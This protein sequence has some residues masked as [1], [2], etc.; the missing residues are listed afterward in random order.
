MS[1]Y[2][3]MKVSPKQLLF[4]LVQDFKDSCYRKCMMII[5]NKNTIHILHMKTHEPY[6]ES[7]CFA[8][9]CY[10]CVWPLIRQL[11]SE[12]QI[13]HLQRELS[14]K[15]AR[16][17]LRLY[18]I[19]SMYLESIIIPLL[20]CGLVN[21][22]MSILIEKSVRNFTNLG[23]FLEKQLWIPGVCLEQVD[24]LLIIL[25]AQQVL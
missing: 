15:C 14:Y 20:I 21:T 2:Q 22:S 23:C 16:I 18:K 17:K 6:N 25:N 12:S 8:S 5:S 13:S 9:K 10:H 7:Y 24:S 19:S 3:N 1:F 11:I 4:V